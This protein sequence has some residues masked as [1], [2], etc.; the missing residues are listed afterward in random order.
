MTRTLG[1]RRFGAYGGDIGSG[2]TKW[3]GA[4]Y[5]EA[6]V[7]IHVTS[8]VVP[9]GFQDGPPTAE[10]QAFLDALTAYHANDQGY[11]AITATR[12]A[13]P[14]RRSG[15]TTTTRRTGR[16]RRSPCPRRSP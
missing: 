9:A 2:V 16:S 6:V 4:L 13:T 12:P 3:L 14:A 5:P 7:G 8:A 1:Y 10:E 15:S 11:A